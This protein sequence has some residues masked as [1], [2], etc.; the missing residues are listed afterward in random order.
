M[1]P[2][3]PRPA[4][5]HRDKSES[6]EAFLDTAGR[7][8]MTTMRHDDPPGDTDIGR[9]IDH[10]IRRG[11][12]TIEGWLTSCDAELIKVV[13][14]AQK[15]FGISGAVGEIGVHHGKL[16]VL[17]DLVRREQEKA[18]AVDVFDLQAL[19]IDNSGKGNLEKFLDNVQKI[20]GDAD[21]VE[22][23]KASS[24]EISW[25]DI[26]ERIGQP[27]RLFSIDGGHTAEITYNDLEIARQ[28]LSTGG[29]IIIDDYF[30]SDWPGVSEGVVKF[31]SQAGELAPF[32]IGQN[33][34]LICHPDYSKK[35]RNYMLDR[36]DSN[37]YRK[38]STFLGSEVSIFRKPGNFY[39]KIRS[40]S[41]AKKYKNYPGVNI[42]KAMMKRIFE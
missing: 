18:F 10:Y 2:G 37:W 5:S 32:A 27:V 9:R 21:R 34:I 29:V 41:F 39:E 23:F 8:D 40:S 16:F 22:V 1:T 4:F 15:A 17:L 11:H 25:Q 31:L 38:K 13:G 42:V 28:S 6:D 14:S 30:N 20:A 7:A 3:R 24:T 33:K 36:I 19:N 12:R 35:Y 26:Y